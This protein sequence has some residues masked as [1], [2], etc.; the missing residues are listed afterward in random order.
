MCL[1]VCIYCCCSLC[2]LV[3]RHHPK[4]ILSLDE[5]LSLRKIVIIKTQSAGDAVADD[6]DIT[7]DRMGNEPPPGVDD[8][9]AIDGG[10][11]G[12]ELSKSKVFTTHLSRMWIV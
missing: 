11:S 3:N 6:D 10:L 7:D 12:V 9:S 5:F 8:L 2:E 4:D 1:S